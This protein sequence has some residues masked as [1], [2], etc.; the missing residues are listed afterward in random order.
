MDKRNIQAA[1]QLK[2][3]RMLP[4]THWGIRF[5]RGDKSIEEITQKPSQPVSIFRPGTKE[6][7]IKKFSWKCAGDLTFENITM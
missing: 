5:E 3:I 7:D 6:S 2:A 4:L 1:Q